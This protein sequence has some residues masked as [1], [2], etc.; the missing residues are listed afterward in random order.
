MRSIEDPDLIQRLIDYGTHLEVCPT[1]N[2]LI[3]IFDSL[4]DHPVDRL[5]RTGVSMGINTDCRGVLPI[6]LKGEYQRLA[7]TFDWHDEHFRLCGLQAAEACFATSA[8]KADLARRIE[9][10]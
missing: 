9:D 10:G 5:Y 2:V 6:T 1:S 3:G 7:A 8:I 4:R